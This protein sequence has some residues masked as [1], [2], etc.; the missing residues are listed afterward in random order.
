MRKRLF[1][2]TLLFPM[3]SNL[4]FSQGLMRVFIRV[5]A[6]ESAIVV[7]REAGV[8]I[9]KQLVP[10]GTA[11]AYQSTLEKRGS[12][13]YSSY[14]EIGKDFRELESYESF[15][16]RKWYED[17]KEHQRMRN[18]FSPLCHETFAQFKERKKD[19]KEH[20]WDTDL[21]CND[22]FLQFRLSIKPKE[23][24]KSPQIDQPKPITNEA[25]KAKKKSIWNRPLFTKNINNLTVITLIPTSKKEF[26]NT[27][28]R[29]P[30]T[31]E[32]TLIQNIQKSSSFSVE[33]NLRK[34]KT[35]SLLSDYFKSNNKYFIIIGHNENGNLILPSGEKININLLDSL[36]GA[37]NLLILSC[38]AQ[39]YTSPASPLYKLTYQEAFKIADQL[40]TLNSKSKKMNDSL[41]T[42]NTM[43]VIEKFNTS[44]KYAFTLKLAK[45]GAGII[46]SL[47]LIDF[48]NKLLAI[49]SHYNL[50]LQYRYSDQTLETSLSVHMCS[51]K[52]STQIRSASA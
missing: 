50:K 3:I 27:F 17:Y 22:V 30:T 51:P 8:Q 38:E 11:L 9:F 10:K 48:I 45:I 24:H 39:L 19:D 18:A 5:L 7:E 1:L 20:N 52:V 34:A 29:T 46:G 49:Q 21:S 2:L 14:N 31:S 6:K 26:T 41:W 25:P 16:D 12:N 36:K 4:V 44:K 43:R 28:G 42:A 47:Y 13:T 40:N 37:K 35:M 15:M 32:L 33:K 23:L